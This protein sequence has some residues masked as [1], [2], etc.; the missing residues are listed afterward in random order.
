MSGTYCIGLYTPNGHRRLEVPDTG[1]DPWN[2]IDE[3]DRRHGTNIYD[4]Y[5]TDTVEF[6][7]RV[8]RELPPYDPSDE[9]YTLTGKDLWDVLS[10]FTPP[11]KGVWF[12]DD[13]YVQAINSGFEVTMQGEDG[14][15]VRQTV[16]VGGWDEED[17]RRAL[18]N[19]HN[20]TDWWE[21]GLGNTVCPSNG[22]PVISAEKVARYLRQHPLDSRRGRSTNRPKASNSRK[23]G[24]SAGRSTK[25]TT[26]GGSRKPAPRSSKNTR[27]KAGA[28]APAK[29]TTKAAPRRR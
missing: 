6:E 20:P 24:T 11:T 16:H 10:P 19:G 25:K 22:C 12:F 2:D 7:S 15:I 23:S 8:A 26:K 18:D 14:G 4:L 1:G 21:D 9:E 17:A 28:K 29:K 13:C 3:Y 27:S 5:D